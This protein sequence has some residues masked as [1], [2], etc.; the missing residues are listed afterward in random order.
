MS[1]VG[2]FTKCSFYYL[3]HRQNLI[4]V[5]DNFFL[6]LTTSVSFGLISPNWWW[7]IS[8]AER[9]GM[10]LTLWSKFFKPLKRTPSWWQPW[11]WINSDI[12]QICHYLSTCFYL[13]MTQQCSNFDMMLLRTILPKAHICFI[14]ERWS[15]GAS[16]K[17][18]AIIHEAVNRSGRRP[19]RAPC[20][21]CTTVTAAMI[22]TSRSEPV[23]FKRTIKHITLVCLYGLF[24]SI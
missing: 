7:H 8:A 2:L 3:Q 16:G 17:E 1:L 4:H 23:K 13:H 11:D 18:R 24:W 22:R 12:P 14:E 19:N 10:R 20:F 6:F 21:S 15:W 5:K 9:E